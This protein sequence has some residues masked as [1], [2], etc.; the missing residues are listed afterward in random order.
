MGV[1]RQTSVGPSCYRGGQL[2]TVNSQP[3]NLTLY[4]TSMIVANISAFLHIQQVSVEAHLCKG[5]C[6][7]RLHMQQ[8]FAK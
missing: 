1:A 2:E 4:C 5:H 7:L 3:C 6:G 8:I